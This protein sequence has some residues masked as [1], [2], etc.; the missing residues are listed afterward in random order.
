LFSLYKQL[1]RQ[2][3]VQ[4][5]IKFA[6]LLRPRGGEMFIAWRSSLYSEAP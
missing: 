6:L 2:R 1:D 3:E 5:R 4:R